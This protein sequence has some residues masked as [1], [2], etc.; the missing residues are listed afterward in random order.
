ME[1]TFFHYKEPFVE[2]NVS[3]NVKGSSWDH[4]CN[5]EPL[6]LCTLYSLYFI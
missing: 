1:K 5:K 4:Q 6:V 2:W 3:M